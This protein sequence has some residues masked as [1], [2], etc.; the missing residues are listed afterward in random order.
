[1]R[2]SMRAFVLD[3]AYEGWLSTL[4]CASEQVAR[5]LEGKRREVP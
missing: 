1:M 2:P 3:T 5:L 4:L